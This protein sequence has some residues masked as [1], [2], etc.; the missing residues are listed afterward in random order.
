VTQWMQLISHQ[1]DRLYIDLHRQGGIP[2][3]S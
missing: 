1:L 3:R 2:G